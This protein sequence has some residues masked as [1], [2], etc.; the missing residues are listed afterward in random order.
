LVNGQNERAAIVATSRS[1]ADLARLPQIEAVER[2]VHDRPACQCEGNN[3]SIDL[4]LLAAL[5]YHKSRRCSVQG[6]GR[7][8]HKAAGSPG[9]A[10]GH[11]QARD[12][13][14]SRPRL[15]FLNRISVCR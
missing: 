12:L 10:C 13:K 9:L 15:V 4:R 3:Q 5:S 11:A 1:T 14:T 2:L 8:T 7:K 6:V